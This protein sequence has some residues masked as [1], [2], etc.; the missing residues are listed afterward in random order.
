MLRN[1]KLKLFRKYRMPGTRIKADPSLTANPDK[2]YNS[3]YY[4]E[5]IIC[6]DCGALFMS[7]AKEKQIYY[8]TNKGNI[9]RR[10]RRCRK[11]DEIKNPHRYLAHNP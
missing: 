1:V 6:Q 5:E 9:Y 3:S 2:F 4:T 8:E 11:C 7:T 10:F